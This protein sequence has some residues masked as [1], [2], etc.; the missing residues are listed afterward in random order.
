MLDGMRMYRYLLI[1]FGFCF[2]PFKLMAADG[3]FTS[4]AHQNNLIIAVEIMVGNNSILV[5]SYVGETIKNL[6][7]RLSEEQIQE[8]GLHA[9]HKIEEMKF[10]LGR[11]P[12]R[13]LPCAGSHYA[14]T[15]DDIQKCISVVEDDIEYPFVSLHVIPVD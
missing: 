6:L 10:E 14:I 7:L 3:H 2:F 8:L 5:E 13:N 11:I 15:T 9:G 1:V 4:A 12:C